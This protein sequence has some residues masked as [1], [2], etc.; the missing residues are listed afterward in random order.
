MYAL[1]SAFSWAFI[2]LWPFDYYIPG[3]FDFL[4][5][6]LEIHILIVISLSIK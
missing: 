5:L 4:L 3:Y 1:Y 2:K 6:L